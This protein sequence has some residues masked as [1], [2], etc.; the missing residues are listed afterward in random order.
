M[1]KDTIA[2]DSQEFERQQRINF[3]SIAVV[4]YITLSSAAYGY[5]GAVIATTLTQPSFHEAM[6]LNTASNANSLIG[7]MNALYYAG[8]I[9]GSFL[10][11]WTS[12]TYGR[13]FSVAM[14]NL[15]LLISGALLCGS[16]NPAVFM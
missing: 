10:A 5:A 1:A 6:G 8:G 2:P 7:A 16:V 14:G 4:S 9:F 12:R 15:L 3:Y 13:K 11:G